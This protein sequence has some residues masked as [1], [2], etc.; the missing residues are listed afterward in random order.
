MTTQ[1]ERGEDRNSVASYVSWDIKSRRERYIR[2]DAIN[3]MIS[4]AP[5]DICV[6]ISIKKL[7]ILASRIVEARTHLAERI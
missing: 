5:S 4:Q 1:C 6:A 2:V 3:T 7:T